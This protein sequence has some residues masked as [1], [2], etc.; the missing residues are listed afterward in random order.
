MGVEPVAKFDCGTTQCNMEGEYCAISIND[1]AG[2]AEPEYFNSCEPL[3]EGCGQGD[4][5]CVQETDFGECYDATGYTM[6]FYPGG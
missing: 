2:E 5:G 1:I 6:T 4:C 3:P